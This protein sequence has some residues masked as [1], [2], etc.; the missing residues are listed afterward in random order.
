MNEL[1]NQTEVTIPVH[2]DHTGDWLVICLKFF[3]L[4]CRLIRFWILHSIN[5]WFLRQRAFIDEA[6]GKFGEHE[7]CVRVARRVAVSNSSF[8]SAHQTSCVLHR[9]THSWRM[10][11]LF[12][13]I[14]NQMEKFFSRGICLLTS[15]AC[16][17]GIR[18]TLAQLNLIRQIY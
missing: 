18:S 3:L 15:W 8:L 6:R 17:I 9:W 1:K 4:I 13:N 10:N 16:T 7:R 2:E 11:Q 5:Y 14:F 12:Y